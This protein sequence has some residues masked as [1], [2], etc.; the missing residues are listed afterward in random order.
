MKY[1]LLT[2]LYK[3]TIILF[4][5]EKYMTAHEYYQTESITVFWGALLCPPAYCYLDSREQVVKPKR[6][7]GLS[8]LL[9]KDFTR[10]QIS[11]TEEVEQLM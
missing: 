11:W 9:D 4:T 3:G 7:G 6:E 8:Y 2:N 1:L 10:K 5:A